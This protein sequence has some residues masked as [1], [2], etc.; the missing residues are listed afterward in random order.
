MARDV[1][2]TAELEE[3][4]WTVV[5]LWDLDVLQDPAAA[6]ARVIDVLRRKGLQYSP[7]P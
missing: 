7:P 3:L 1:A 6:A 2:I 4:G 5:R